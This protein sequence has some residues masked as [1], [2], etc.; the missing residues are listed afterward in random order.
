MKHS[1]TR[2]TFEQGEGDKQQQKEGAGL[3]GLNV[4]A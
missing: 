3:S 4:K 2:F 1:T